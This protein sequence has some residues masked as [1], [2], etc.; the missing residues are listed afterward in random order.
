MNKE[1][2]KLMRFF[3][4]S[5]FVEQVHVLGIRSKLGFLLS[6]SDL[7]KKKYIKNIT[8][9]LLLLFPDLHMVLN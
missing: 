6:D 4:P 7:I 5:G 8:S 2:N 1:K 9:L 3:I